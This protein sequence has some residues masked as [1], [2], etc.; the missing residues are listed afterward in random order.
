MRKKYTVGL[1]VA[2][3]HYAQDVISSATSSQ[4]VKK[5]ANV[6]LMR[7]ENVGKPASQEEVAK[8]CGVSDVTVYHTIREYCE[9]GIEYALTY[10]KPENAP[11]PAIVGG[12]SE[13]RIIA[14]ACGEPPEGFSRW[15]VRLLTDKVVELAILPTV[16]RETVRR[17][18]KKHNLNLT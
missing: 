15:T 10:K 13:A 1:T 3:R 12:E 4:S 8:R 11:R 5:R 16:S 9:H 2:E 14:L 17:T 7:D 18:L 6:L